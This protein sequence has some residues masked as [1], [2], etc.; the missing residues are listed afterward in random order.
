MASRKRLAKILHVNLNEK[1]EKM[2]SSV[3]QRIDLDCDRINFQGRIL[4]SISR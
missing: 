2:I 4:F 3:Q 1:D